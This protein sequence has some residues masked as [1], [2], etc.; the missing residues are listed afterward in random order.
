[1]AE[2]DQTGEGE[3][4]DWYAEYVGRHA[5]LSMVWSQAPGSEADEVRGVTVDAASERAVGCL[6][7]GRV[8]IWDV[9]DRPGK[10]RTFRLVAQSEPGLLLQRPSSYSQ[11]STDHSKPSFTGTVEC[12]NLDS[13][14]QRAY[15]AVD[16]YLNEIDLETLQVISQEPYAWKITSLS[17]EEPTN[18]PISVGTSWS[19][20]LYDPRM[21]P[22]DRSRSPE[23]LMRATPGSP[24]ESI[25]F[26]PN[27]NKRAAPTCRPLPTNPPP[28]FRQDRTPSRPAQEDYWS[29]GRV[30]LS[31]FATVEPGPLS[32]LNHKEHDIL[33]AGRFPSILLYDRRCFPRLQSVLH[34]GARLSSIATIPYP[35]KALQSATGPDT[36]LVAAGEY[37]GRGSLELYSLPPARGAPTRLSDVNEHMQPSPEPNSE[38]PEV[39]ADNQDEPHQQYSFKNRQEASSAKL[40]SVATQGTRIV[41]ADAEGGLKWVERDGRGLARRWNVNSYIATPT[42]GALSS[43]HVARKIVPLDTGRPDGDLLIF[44]GDRLGIVTTKPQFEDHEELVRAFEDGVDV[45][46]REERDKVDEYSRTMRLALEGQADERRWMS[47]FNRRG[48]F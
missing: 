38:S 14:N 48:L 29:R 13:A 34:S 19:L 23:D 25:A 41:F 20:H 44:T 3:D 32:I 16:R 22:R 28:V 7:D 42:G 45:R 36:T 47:R 37:G 11:S 39:A 5:P 17:Q 46:E 26:L 31:D 1:M 2:W 21:A 35:P 8:A 43:E 12:V 18:S 24:E 6:E 9:S 30:E 33:L 40:L 27:Y 10:Q 15:V 4:V